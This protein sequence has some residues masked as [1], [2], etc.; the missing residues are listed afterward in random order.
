MPI[1]VQVEGTNIYGSLCELPRRPGLEEFGQTLDIVPT[2]AV[3]PM[4]MRFEAVAGV[5]DHVGQRYQN[6]AAEDGDQ[7]A[8]SDLLNNMQYYSLESSDVIQK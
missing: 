2:R 6:E 5:F 1:K 4:Q 3:Y 8:G 7:S